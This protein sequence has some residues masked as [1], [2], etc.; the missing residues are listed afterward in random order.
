VIRRLDLPLDI[1]MSFL[2]FNYPPIFEQAEAKHLLKMKSIS[3]DH[4]SLFPPLSSS[5]SPSPSLPVPSYDS[6][7]R[8][9]RMSEMLSEADLLYTCQFSTNFPLDRAHS[10]SFPT[11]RYEG[12]W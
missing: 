4:L 11:G 7:E 6:L 3:T 12:G 2:Q 10:S 9:E 1:A 5:P 8:A